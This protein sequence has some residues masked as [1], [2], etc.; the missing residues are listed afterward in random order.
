MRLRQKQQRLQQMLN[1]G[2]VYFHKFFSVLSAHRNHKNAVDAA[3]VPGNSLL[4]CKHRK[5]GA[6]RVQLQRMRNREGIH[7]AS[8]R[9]GF[10]LQH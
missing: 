5:A 1:N 7:K 10:P 8:G 6:C 9:H 2:A 4:I 3:V